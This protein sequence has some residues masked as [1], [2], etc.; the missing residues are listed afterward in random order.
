MGE[1]IAT[2]KE[3]KAADFEWYAASSHGDDAYAITIGGCGTSYEAGRIYAFKADVANTGACTL[4]INAIGALTIKKNLNVDLATDDILAGQIVA[5]VYDGTYFQMLSRIGIDTNVAL[6]SSDGKVPSQNAVKTY[7]DG[8]PATRKN[9][10]ITR[11][12][13]AATGAVNTAHGLGRTPK[14][15]RIS[16]TAD[17]GTFHTLA[18]SIGSYDGTNTSCVYNGGSVQTSVGAYSTSGNS[19]SYVVWVAWKNAGGE[20]GQK[21][22]IAVDGTNITL[23]WADLSSTI[24]NTAKILWEV[25]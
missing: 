19:N 6:G 12:L 16:A 1:K 24:A 14:K 15:V 13:D 9:G 20:V 4:N 7:V 17:D 23:T 21:A 18:T 25:E 2:A 11:A 3:V 8:S 10:T 22:T 5:V